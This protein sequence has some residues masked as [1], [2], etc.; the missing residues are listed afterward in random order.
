[1]HHMRSHKT[2]KPM[3]PSQRKAQAQRHI[4]D[5]FDVPIWLISPD[6]KPPIWWKIRQIPRRIRAA[7]TKTDPHYPTDYSSDYQP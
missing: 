3:T 2:G 6:H 1:M 7:L 4:A 5:A